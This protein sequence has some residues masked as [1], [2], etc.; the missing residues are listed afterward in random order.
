MEI[1][2]TL[3]KIMKKHEGLPGKKRGDS[4]KQEKKEMPLPLRQWHFLI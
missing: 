3:A 2:F 4:G 1:F